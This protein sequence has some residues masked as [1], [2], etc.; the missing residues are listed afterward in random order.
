MKRKTK[1]IPPSDSS[2][3]DRPPV[4]AA[5]PDERLLNTRELMEF[6]NLSR[7]KVWDLVNNHGLPA[8]RVGGDYRYLRSEVLAWLQQYRVNAGEKDADEQE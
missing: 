8:Y 2:Q 1:K 4:P 7:S 3:P 5:V 6:M